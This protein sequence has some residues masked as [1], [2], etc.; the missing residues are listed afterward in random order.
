MKYL[1]KQNDDVVRSAT[2]RNDVKK[3]DVI[4][5]GL[6]KICTGNH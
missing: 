4:V 2:I 1:P 3:M 5:G 6:C